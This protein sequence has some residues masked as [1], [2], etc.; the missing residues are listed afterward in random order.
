MLQKGEWSACL[1]LVTLFWH[2]PKKLKEI[3]LHNPKKLSAGE[4]IDQ[5]ITNAPSEM[6]KVEVYKLLFFRVYQRK[7]KLIICKVYG[8]TGQLI[9]IG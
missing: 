6:Y 3:F 9:Y 4:F 7:R 1:G 8:T 2:H 5:M